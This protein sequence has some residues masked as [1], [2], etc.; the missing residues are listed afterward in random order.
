M[1]AVPD[2]GPGSDVEIL[3]SV[4]HFLHLEQPRLIADKIT[5]WLAG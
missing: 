4:G 1:R 2:V 5:G 3:D